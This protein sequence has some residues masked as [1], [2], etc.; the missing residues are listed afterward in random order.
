MQCALDEQAMRRSWSEW[1]AQ[2]FITPKGR[3]GPKAEH[4]VDGGF[5]LARVDRPLGP[6][7]YGNRVGGFQVLC[8]ACEGA[9]AQAWG[10]AVEGLKATGHWTLDCPI[11]GAPQAPNQ[12]L[13]RPPAALARFAV[14]LRDVGSSVLRDRSSFEALLGS[15][16]RVIGVR[17]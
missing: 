12:S 17:G 3:A 15:D 7:V 6:A 13:T 10:G 8:S 16:F 1:T 4:W 14:E 5:V 2:G 11:C 9:I